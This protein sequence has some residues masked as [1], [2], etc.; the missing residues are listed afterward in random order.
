[1]V[2]HFINLTFRT[3]SKLSYKCFYAL[4]VR[5]KLFVFLDLAP[6]WRK[7]FNKKPL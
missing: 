3:P 5:R 7:D 2:I 4:S 6:P 1:M